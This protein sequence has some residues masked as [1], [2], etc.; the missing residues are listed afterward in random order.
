M[1]ARYWSGCAIVALFVAVAPALIWKGG[2]M[3]REATSFIP[4]YTDGRPVLQ[5]L[6]DPQKNDWGMYQA[7]EL[8]Y[9]FDYV[10][11][12][13]YRSVYER[14]GVPVFIP[15]SGVLASVLLA[16]VFFRG[17]SRTAEN[18]D[19][20]TAALL[21]GCFASSFVF[22]ST[23]AV[24]YRSAK[25][26]LSVVL[27]GLLFHV[28]AVDRQ[29]RSASSSHILTRDTIIACVLGLLCGLL[30]RQGFVYVVIGCALVALH[31]ASTKRLKDTLLGLV[32]AAVFL[33]AY[34]YELAPM[35]IHALNGYWPDFKYQRVPLPEASVLAVYIMVAAK[36][37][38]ENAALLAGGAYVTAALLIGALVAVYLLAGGTSRW[39][40]SFAD[41]QRRLAFQPG[42]RVIAYWALAFGTQVLMFALMIARHPYVYAYLDHRYWYYPFPFVVTVLFGAVSLL[43]AVIAWRSRAVLTIVRGLL[44]LMIVGN[45]AFLPARRRIMEAGHWFNPVSTQSVAL[46]RSLAAGKADPGLDADY[47]R[48]FERHTAWRAK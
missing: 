30:D 34:N 25:G 8:S 41:V 46:K 3:E 12:V 33:V 28:R 21:F 42:R 5:K 38:I 11:A 26:L 4:Q 36:M 7:R 23:M 27:L 13:V 14:F 6:F 45:L 16:L 35:A 18:I 2:T 19:P 40:T 37:M 47:H 39:V 24:F 15:L 22:I 10:D 43:D 29:Q 48:F 31:V 1:A 17:V 9:V 44:I 32:I 20:P